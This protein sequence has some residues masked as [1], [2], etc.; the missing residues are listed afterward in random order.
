M[1]IHDLT[2]GTFLE[3]AIRARKEGND[4]AFAGYLASISDETLNRLGGL[5]V[6]VL[7]GTCPNCNPAAAWT[8]PALTAHR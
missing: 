6:A 8:P 5:L 3:L 2:D 4:A 7:T 1:A